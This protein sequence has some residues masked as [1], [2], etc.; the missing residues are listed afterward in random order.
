MILVNYSESDTSDVEADAG[1]KKQTTKAS[2]RK[3]VD[4]ADPHKI[5]ISLNEDA[6]NATS[7]EGEIG[8]AHV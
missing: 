5:R 1:C 8:R 4:R 2:F 3:V 6:K 7:E